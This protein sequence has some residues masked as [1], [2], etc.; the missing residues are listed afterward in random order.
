MRWS[1]KKCERKKDNRQVWMPARSLFVCFC[2]AAALV[3]LVFYGCGN[4]KMASKG[5]WGCIGPDKRSF[6]QEEEGREEVRKDGLH[7]WWLCIMKTKTKNK[8]MAERL[9]LQT[10]R[11]R[12]AGIRLFRRSVVFSKRGGGGI[13]QLLRVVCCRE[14]YPKQTKDLILLV[15]QQRQGGEKQRGRCQKTRFVYSYL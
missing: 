5:K 11:Q 15:Q 12:R 7:A 13:G 10:D 2:F 9:W 14:P 8:D 3:G 6:M 4:E 1:Q